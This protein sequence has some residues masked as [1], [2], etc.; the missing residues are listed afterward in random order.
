[1]FLLAASKT[2]RPHIVLYTAAPRV[3]QKLRRLSWFPNTKLMFVR[4]HKIC[5]SKAGIYQK[6]DK[7]LLKHYFSSLSGKRT[8]SGYGYMYHSFVAIRAILRS[9]VP[10]PNVNE[11]TSASV[12]R[13]PLC[14]REQNIERLWSIS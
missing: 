13:T 7:Y 9:H 6:P 12:T 5:S 4:W 11:K 2:R 10:S 1:M 3:A 14:L 8:L